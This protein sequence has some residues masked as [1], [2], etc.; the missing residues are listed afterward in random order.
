MS[1]GNV[2][3]LR[4]CVDAFRRG[5]LDAVLQLVD[6]EVVFIAARS[7]V[8][9]AYRGHDGIRTFL[10][11]TAESFDVFDPAFEEIRD[12]G[13]RLVA[14]GSIR[15]R[16]RG[17]SVETNIPMAGVFTFTTDGKLARWE[18]FRERQLALEAVGLTE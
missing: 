16:G 6:T 12:L 14:F 11:D 5:D 18:D 8:E 3:V 17:S 13:D 15:V 7:A 10:A 2:D 4:A 1:D 9:G